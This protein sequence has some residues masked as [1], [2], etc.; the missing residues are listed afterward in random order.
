M[1]VREWMSTKPVTIHSNASITEALRTMRQSQVRRLPVLDENG[2]MV[3][4]VS[5]KD[6]FYA[7]PSPVTSLSIYE[8]HYML[9]ELKVSELMTQEVI[10]VSPDTPL[11][12]EA[13][14]PKQE[15]TYRV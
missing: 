3:G 8:M 15:G 4:I 13:N 10:T 12:E 7:S 5:E 2:T 14:T 1:L 9:S 11:E 6:L